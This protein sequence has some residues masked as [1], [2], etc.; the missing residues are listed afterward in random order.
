MHTVAK[1]KTQHYV[2]LDY[3][4]GKLFTK[5]TDIYVT[6]SIHTYFK[7]QINIVI[8]ERKEICTH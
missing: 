7:I 1:F 6:L 2:H 8:D 4:N 3:E 5:I